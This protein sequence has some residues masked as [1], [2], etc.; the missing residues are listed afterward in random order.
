VVQVVHG[1]GVVIALNIVV[2][3]FG[4]DGVLM[5]GAPVLLMRMKNICV[6]PKMVL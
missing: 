2:M 5:L 6:A 4:K 3:I 1:I